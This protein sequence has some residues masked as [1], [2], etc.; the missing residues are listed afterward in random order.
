MLDALHATAESP[1]E[2]RLPAVD[3]GAARELALDLL[4]HEVQHHG[5]LIRFVYGNGLTFPESWKVR[6]TVL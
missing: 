1:D 3:R 5:Q 2:D 6:Y 4:E